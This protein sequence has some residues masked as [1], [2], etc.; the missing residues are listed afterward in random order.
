MQFLCGKHSDLYRKVIAGP[1]EVYICD[2]CV[3]LCH[4]IL[5]EE[6]RDGSIN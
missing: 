2:E 3:D 6:F 4:E 5:E 1:K